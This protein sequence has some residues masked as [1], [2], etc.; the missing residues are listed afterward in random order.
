MHVQLGSN[1][2]WDYRTKVRMIL[3]KVPSA[4][5]GQMM[6]HKRKNER[7]T[8]ISLSKLA[9]SARRGRK[10]HVQLGSNVDSS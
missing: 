7:N 9:K 8:H 1:V 5:F 2:A 3:A 4:F 10:M 6:G